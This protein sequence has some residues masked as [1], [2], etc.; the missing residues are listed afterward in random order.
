MINLINKKSQI[1]KNKMSKFDLSLNDPCQTSMGKCA[2]EESAR[3]RTTP[4]SSAVHGTGNLLL[5][6]E[7]AFPLEK[8]TKES[9]TFEGV[10][11]RD[12]I[13]K[14][15]LGEKSVVHS[16]SCVCGLGLLYPLITLF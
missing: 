12:G 7:R 14:L 13:F 6:S 4:L 8:R 2:Q 3:E 1:A 10:K 16:Q 11:N 9:L 15:N 5:E